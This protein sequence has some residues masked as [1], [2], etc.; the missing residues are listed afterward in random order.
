MQLKVCA[1]IWSSRG[2]LSKS[3]PRRHT[4]CSAADGLFNWI[5]TEI[6]K[7]GACRCNRCDQGSSARRSTVGRASSP[8]QPWDQRGGIPNPYRILRRNAG[9]CDRQLPPPLSG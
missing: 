9:T 1:G 5:G 7:C 3:W 8:P 6:E 4:W 2:P